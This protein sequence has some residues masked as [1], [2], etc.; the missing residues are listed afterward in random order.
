MQMSEAEERYDI[1]TAC[2]WILGHARN[3]GIPALNETLKDKTADMCSDDELR[4]VLQA[5]IEA[6][7]KLYP[8]KAG[9]QRLQRRMG[10]SDSNPGRKKTG[11]G[12]EFIPEAASKT[13][14]RRSPSARLHLKRRRSK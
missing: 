10:S 2:A 4:H 9:T 7:L 3:T 12:N 13:D 8:F 6:K 1:R 14:H 5:G 11:M